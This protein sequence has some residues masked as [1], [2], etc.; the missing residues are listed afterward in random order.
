MSREVFIQ[1]GVFGGAEQFIAFKNILLLDLK[2]DEQFSVKLLEFNYLMLTLPWQIQFPQSHFRM[3]FFR[4]LQSL[5]SSIY[6]PSLE[7]GKKF[8]K[9]T[10]KTKAK[11]HFLTNICGFFLKIFSFHVFSH[12]NCFIKKFICTWY[13]QKKLFKLIAHTF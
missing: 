7:P 6:I 13:D 8:K 5:S 9:L 2:L 12:K 1:G 11:L 3:I 10:M 4:N